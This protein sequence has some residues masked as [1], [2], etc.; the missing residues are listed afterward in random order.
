M[1]SSRADKKNIL[2]TIYSSECTVFSFRKI[3][4]L[5]GE[6]NFQS[7]NNKLNYAVRTGKL[8]NP[9]KGIYTK[10]NYNKEELACSVY[11]PSYI[12]LDYTLQKAGIIFQYDSTITSISYLSRAL[13]IEKQNY[14]FRKIKASIL[15]NTKGIKRQN[16]G[17]NIATT[18]RAFLD[19]LYLEKNYHFD[20]LNPI[21]KKIINE[22]LPFYQ[23]K[24]L[25]E[26]VSKLLN[27]G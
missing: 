9:R 19:L 16:N 3:A 10:S 18:E 13:E 26:R 11:A 7:L 24:A 23:S 6:Q 4:L 15:Y 22:L 21:N 17:I 1:L 14:R 20:N 12:S 8:L 2:L 25:N 5:T 27:N